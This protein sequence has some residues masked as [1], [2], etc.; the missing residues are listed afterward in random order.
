MIALAVRS[1][2][3]DRILAS[4]RGRSE[5]N[6]RA[7]NGKRRDVYGGRDVRW[8]VMRRLGAN[9]RSWLRHS[10]RCLQA[11]QAALRMCA[12]VFAT[13]VAGAADVG[14]GVYKVCRRRCGGA[15]GCL[16]RL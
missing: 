12:A 11:L 3:C 6:S 1:A 15:E 5:K 14:R 2:R 7:Q 16:Q 9:A 10:E 8:Q 4:A 13:F